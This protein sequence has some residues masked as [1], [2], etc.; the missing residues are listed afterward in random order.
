MAVEALKGSRVITG[1]LP[2]SSPRSMA[3]PGL[4]GGRV[5]VW[6]ET[7][8]VSPAASATSTYHMARLPSN[9]RI[10]GKS[11]I[12]YDDLASTGTPTVRIGVFNPPGL[13]GI[14]DDDDALNASINVYTAA[15]TNANL[16]TPI[17][18]FG[19]RLWEM[20]N[21]QTTDPKQELDIKITLDA[22]CNTGG[23]FMMEI[24]YTMD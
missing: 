5:R 20:V 24:Y 2:T 4:A 8:E 10:L 15:V 14:N 23:T 19:K 9:A 13:S 16:L 11:T 17:D 1:L 12:S 7:V 6:S 3:A 22:D 18:Y 21:G